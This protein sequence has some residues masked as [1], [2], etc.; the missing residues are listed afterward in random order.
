MK[1]FNLF[2]DILITKGATRIIISDLQRNVSELFPLELYD[3]IKEFKEKSIEDIMESYDLESQNFIKDYI[4]V[5]LENEFGFITEGNWDHNFLPFSYE[6]STPNE[7]ANAF[8]EI[9]NIDILE[10]IIVVLSDLGCEQVVIH[11]DKE[12]S[13]EQFMQIENYFKNSS[14]TTLEIFSLYSDNVN[15]SL[16]AGVNQFCSRIYSLIFYC[17][18]KKLFKPKNEYKFVVT[19]TEEQI[20]LNSC[21]KV[22]LKYFNTNLPKVLEAINHNSCL[23]KK[24]SIDKDGNIKNCPSMSESFGNIRDTT[25]EEALQ[26]KDFKKYWNLTKDN[27]EVCKDCEFRYICTDCR[28]YTERT[29]ISN[30]GFDTSKPL[31]CGY[32]PY[33]GEWEEWSKNPLKQ[34]AINFYDMKELVKNR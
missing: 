18:K 28:A 32:N 30:V 17:C 29:H 15:E 33:T 23:H 27:I 5:L 20:K 26:H 11:Y 2:S 25:L 31:K 1:Y 12:L 19:F 6:F 3:V 21:G 14:V 34:K 22:D 7:I 9:E 10:K 4:N 24:I 16:L 13:L 8:L